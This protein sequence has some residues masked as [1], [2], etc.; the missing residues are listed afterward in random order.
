MPTPFEFMLQYRNLSVNAPFDDPVTRTCRVETHRVQIRKYFMMNWTEGTDQRLD[1][2]VVTRGLNND[3]WFRA[4]QERISTAAMG[5]GA[6]HDYEL[7]L[8]W[9]VRSKKIPLVN[10]G[11]LQAYCDDHLGID[12]SGFATNYLCANGIKT[13]SSDTVRNTGAAS[14]YD[15]FCSIDDPA[16]IRQGDLLVWMNGNHVK[17]DPGHVAVVESYLPQSRE[18][19]NMRVVE[20]TA[21]ATAQ[22][23][24]LDSMYVVERIVDPTDACP[25]MVLVV[26]RHGHS[27]S[28]V[29]VIRP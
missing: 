29:A 1:Y 7:A 14:Y 6:P 12:C 8:E 17:R 28:R 2:A 20:S 24:L 10:Q 22:P 23:K 16:L 5:K 13:Y 26:K 4:N 19:G 27:G 9:A 11:T 18:G 21:T 25:V 3:Q 15:P